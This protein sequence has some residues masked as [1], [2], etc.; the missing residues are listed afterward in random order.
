VKDFQPLSLGVVELPAGKGEL[1]LLA[2]KV[3]GKQVADI[4]AL[5][6]VLVP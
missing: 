3:A 4:R 6:L 1:A 5:E 2:T